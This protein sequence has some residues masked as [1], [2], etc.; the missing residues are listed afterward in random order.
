MSK[1]GYI[2]G[3]YWAVCDRC[4]FEYRNSRLVTE[5]WTGLRVC[6]K[7]VDPKPIYPTQEPDRVAVPIPR[8]ENDT[9]AND[10]DYQYYGPNLFPDPWIDPDNNSLWSAGTNSQQH[11]YAE[12]YSKKIDATTSEITVFG[13]EIDST[14]KVSASIWSSANSSKV[15]FNGV[16]TDLFDLIGTK[17]WISESELYSATSTELT[18]TFDAGTE[19]IYIDNI[20]VQLE[21]SRVLSSADIIANKAPSTVND[22]VIGTT[23][24]F[25]SFAGHDDFNSRGFGSDSSGG[26]FIKGA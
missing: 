24:N 10:A 20:Y 8:P 15:Y 5:E 26:I 22:G 3:D 13:L 7:C 23:I 12:Y 25:F 21:E 6:R 11:V 4:G 17:Q 14:Y 9:I 1:R 2:P 19:T 16:E 18:I